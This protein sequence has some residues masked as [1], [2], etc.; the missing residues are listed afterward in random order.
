MEPDIFQ[1]LRRLIRRLIR[2]AAR[3]VDFHRQE[4]KSLANVIMQF[5]GDSASLLF[6]RGEEPPTQFLLN[7]P[8]ARTLLHD[9]SKNHEG[10]RSEYQE[11]LQRQDI[12]H[13]FWPCE[14]SAPIHGSPN[15]QNEITIMEVLTPNEPNLKAAHRSNGTK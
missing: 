5:P 1:P 15:G 7:K 10:S 9:G 6:L 12:A 4:S 3:L 13:R 11:H 14:G 2:A 8:G